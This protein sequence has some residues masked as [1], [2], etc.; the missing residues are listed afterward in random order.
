MMGNQGFPS[1]VEIGDFGLP[2]LDAPGKYLRGRM[3]QPGRKAEKSP[4]LAITPLPGLLCPVMQAC[5]SWVGLVSEL[6]SR[7]RAG[8]HAKSWSFA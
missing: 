8:E 5:Y 2:F 7:A 6:E 4:H 1:T 3:A